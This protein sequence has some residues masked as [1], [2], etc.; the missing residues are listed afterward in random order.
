M[1]NNQSDNGKNRLK[2]VRA[3][4][5]SDESR[6]QVLEQFVQLTGQILNIPARFIS[7]VDD[8]NQDIKAVC[9]FALKQTA[10]EE[11]LCRHIPDGEGQLVVEDTL[12]DARFSTYPFVKGEPFIRFYAGVSLTNQKGNAFGTLCVADVRPHKF[13]QVQITTLNS[14][15]KLVA[16]LLEAWNSADSADS[17]DVTTRLPDRRCLIRDIQ[18]LARVEPA[19]NYRLIVIDCID[20][21]RIHELSRTVGVVPVENLLKQI[22]LLVAERLRLDEGKKLY[23]FAPGRFAIIQGVNDKYQ[24][25]NIVD[26]LTG[27]NASLSENILIDLDIFIG[28]TTFIPQKLSANE[29]LRQAVSALHEAIGEGEGATPFHEDYDTRRTEDFLI[30]N[31]LAAALKKDEGFY[32]V[33]Q[34][35]VCLRTGKTVGLEALIRW[36]H[37]ERGELYPA[38]FIPLAKKTNLLSDLTEWI[39]DRLIAQLACWKKEYALI[40]V[41]INVS[42]KDFAKPD[43]ASRLAARVKQAKLSTA[44]IGI[45]CLENE[46]ITE[47]DVAIKGL[48]SLK[49][50]GFFISLDDFGKGY[51]NINYLQDIPL[52]VIKIDLSLITRLAEEGSSRIIVNSIIHMLKE[53]NYTVLAEGVETEAVLNLLKQYGCDQIQGYFFSKPLPASEIEHWLYQNRA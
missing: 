10:R 46:L 22:A 3:L 43:F 50:H 30:M 9:N 5:S 36:N 27:M 21:P 11:T 47:K 49:S 52:D 53:L 18:Q 39:I 19:Q 24:A 37:P 15:A 35:K 25:H 28:E 42:E 1:Q 48:K 23:C 14:L 6:E 32:L 7:I 12:L 26:V 17:A 40:P 41:S 45:E 20:M 31:D 4:L 16:S 8:D 13:S 51:S 34:P 38:E 33:Y 29:I 44:L 2:A